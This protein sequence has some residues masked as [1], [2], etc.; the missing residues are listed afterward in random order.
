MEF[1]ISNGAGSASSSSL[2]PRCIDFS[3]H[4]C[5]REVET[6]ATYWPAEDKTDDHGE[7]EAYVSLT[8]KVKEQYYEVPK[9]ER[10]I[11]SRK[12]AVEQNIYFDVEMAREIRDALS[13]ALDYYEGE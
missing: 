13:K 2:T 8:L 6:R 9:D 10:D 4:T 11:L 7:R 1:K 5:G 12:A 3:L